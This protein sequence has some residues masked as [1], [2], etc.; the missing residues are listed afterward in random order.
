MTLTS[1]RLP[2]S[3]Q[4]VEGGWR[5]GL[6]GIE[7]TSEREGKGLVFPLSVYP[8][9]LH[10]HTAGG[11]FQEDLQLYRKAAHPFPLKLGVISRLGLSLTNNK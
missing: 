8:A 2:T 4:E 10:V 3:F 11:L 6:K 7:P 1:L 9:G 5:K